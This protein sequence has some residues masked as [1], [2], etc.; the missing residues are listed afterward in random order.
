MASDQQVQEA[1][2]QQRDQP[3]VQPEAPA[4]ADT[5]EA[6][7]DDASIILDYR[8]ENGRRYHRL[9]NGK[10]VWPNDEQ[11]QERLDIVNHLWM[12]TL[13]G[14]FCL[15]PKNKHARRVLDLGTG[16]GAWALDY[17]DEHPKSRVIGVDL[18]PIQPSY[19]P[20]NC[21]FEIDDLEKDWTWTEPFDFI[22]ARNMI[23]SFSDWD[24]AMEQAYEHLEPGGYF[25]IQD[26]HWPITCDD[27][28]LRG[29]P[30]ER[31]THM[32]ADAANRTGRPL[33]KTAH[34]SEKMT[35]AGFVNV[36][37]TRIRFPASPWPK[38]EKLRELG[39]WTQ[40][41]VLPGIEGMSL[42]LF[43]RVLDWS[44]AETIVF[45]AQVREKVKDTKIHAY[46]NG[47]VIHSR[48]PLNAE[49]VGHT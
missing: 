10:Y 27:D 46:W 30:L 9:S 24:R 6:D 1:T 7:D 2:H 22:L 20:P 32:M 23:L 14:A 37:K 25:E 43:T 15:C 8:R 39:Y 29:T 21:S 11:E 45:C 3:P 47:H 28:T 17:A 41:S 49:Q 13:D 5:V 12:L 31:W 34:L 44:A 33:D 18:S 40:A 16:T 42:A 35:A 48:K 4:V 26:S 38:D 36:T 19:V